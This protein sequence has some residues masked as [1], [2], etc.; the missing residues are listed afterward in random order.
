MVKNITV[1]TDAVCVLTL[2]ITVTGLYK[3]HARSR[4]FVHCSLENKPSK[5]RFISQQT[6]Y[7]ILVNI[8]HKVVKLLKYHTI[9]FFFAKFVESL[10]IVSERQI[11]ARQSSRRNFKKPVGIF[12]NVTGLQLL[13]LL[14]NL[15]SCL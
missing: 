14:E 6:E 15:L 9:F 4:I 1:V 7:Y 12:R 11:S 8:M 3:L 13:V 10:R 5:H 2:E